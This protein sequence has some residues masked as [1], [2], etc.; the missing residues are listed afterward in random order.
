MLSKNH[1]KFS[2]E[3]TWKIMPNGCQ[4]ETKIDARTHQ[5]SADPL[6]GRA[7]TL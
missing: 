7:R 2:R 6:V 1:S 3:K 4:N 5:K